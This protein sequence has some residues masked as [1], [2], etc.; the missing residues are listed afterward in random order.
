ML[1]SLGCHQTLLPNQ[2]IRDARIPEL[3]EVMA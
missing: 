3:Q 2:L 1:G